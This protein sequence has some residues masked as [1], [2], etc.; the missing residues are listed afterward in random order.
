M[1]WGTS[2]MQSSRTSAGVP[3]GHPAPR[4][5]ATDSVMEVAETVETA[6]DSEDLGPLVRADGQCAP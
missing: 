3:N 6:L 5:L 2:A 1:G 4:A